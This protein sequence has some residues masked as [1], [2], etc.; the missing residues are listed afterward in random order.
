MA[1]QMIKV[2]LVRCWRDEITPV[3]ECYAAVIVN[4]A[5][6]SFL[7]AANLT[8]DSIIFQNAAKTSSYALIDVKN[9]SWLHLQV[10]L[11]LLIRINDLNLLQNVKFSNYS[12][13]IKN[14][15]ILSESNSTIEMENTTF[16]GL[17]FASASLIDFKN[18]SFLMREVIVR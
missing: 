13:N 9:N 18:G 17:N 15:L 1:F 8:F 4:S 16:S 12:M 11:S 5:D 2:S 6:V 7:V 3:S 10:L 14:T